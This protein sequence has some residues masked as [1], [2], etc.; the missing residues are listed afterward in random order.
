M[1]TPV[2]E[3]DEKQGGNEDDGTSDDGPDGTKVQNSVAGPNLFLVSSRPK[4]G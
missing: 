4:R 2:E 1:S 3:M